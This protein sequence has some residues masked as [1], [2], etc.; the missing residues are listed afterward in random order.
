MIV[1][2]L[3]SLGNLSS[4]VLLLSEHVTKHKRRTDEPI[5]SLSDVTSKGEL[6]TLKQ[7]VLLSTTNFANPTPVPLQKE[8]LLKPLWNLESSTTFLHTHLAK[9]RYNR[10][11]SRIWWL[12]LNSL[13]NFH[14]QKSADAN[15]P[16]QLLRELIKHCLFTHVTSDHS[17]IISTETSTKIRPTYHSASSL[18]SS[19]LHRSCW[20][21]MHE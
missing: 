15:L 2:Q 18:L 8:W 7:T 13:P 21:L 10:A 20:L 9:T 17:Q 5:T 16:S 14:S 3:C 12:P 1:Q 6:L 4:K 19:W 11:K